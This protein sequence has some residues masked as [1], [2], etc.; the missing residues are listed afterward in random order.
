[1]Y[2][3]SDIGLLVFDWSG[4]ISDDR[5]PVYEANMRILEDY[6]KPTISFEEWLP[7]TTMTPVE[8]LKNHGVFGDDKKM[9]ALYKK[10]FDEAV[11][12]GTAPTAYADACDVLRY[13]KGRKKKLSVLSSHPAENLRKEAEQYSLASFL[14]LIE[15]N[16]KD[17]AGGL[18]DICRHLGE[19]PE[20]A[21]YVGDTIYDIRAAK[22]AGTRSAGICTGYHTK[23]RLESEMPDFILGCL[24]ELKGVF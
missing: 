14:E 18:L 21:L 23:E 20:S 22:E 19:K 3:A 1:M 13:L 5:M 15:G 12:S 9:F 2:D 6:G 10:Y 24:S 7:R 17:K 16:S 4:V 8:F 11:E